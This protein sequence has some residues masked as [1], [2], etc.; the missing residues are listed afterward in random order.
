MSFEPPTRRLINRE[1]VLPG[2]GF[3]G[4]GLTPPDYKLEIIRI[5]ENPHRAT[6]TPFRLEAGESHAFISERETGFLEL[7]FIVLDR[8][9][10]EIILNIDDMPMGV[11]AAWLRTIGLDNPGVNGW[12]RLTADVPLGALP[13][14]TLIYSPFGLELYEDEVRVIVQAPDASALNVR[15]F[16]CRRYRILDRLERTKVV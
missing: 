1:S 10:A 11:T 15:E 7:I 3:P 16:F 2:Q 12:W 6:S 5:P 4:P 9:D 14:F 8:D 13:R